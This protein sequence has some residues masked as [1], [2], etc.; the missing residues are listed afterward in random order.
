M[1]LGAGVRPV[2]A[3][4]IVVVNSGEP[5]GYPDAGKGSPPGWAPWK[6][7]W[8]SSRVSISFLQ[9]LQLV[10][11]Y[12]TPVQESETGVVCPPWFRPEIPVFGLTSRF[13]SGMIIAKYRVRSLHL[14]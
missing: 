14:P 10:T 4:L 11:H 5:R 1:I 9:L 3:R 12:A 7:G 6:P 8:V 13:C 2:V